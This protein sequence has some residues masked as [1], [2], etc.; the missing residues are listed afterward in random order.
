MAEPW[1]LINIDGQNR[2]LRLDGVALRDFQLA[3][4]KSIGAENYPF[5]KVL[6]R[7]YEQATRFEVVTDYNLLAHL[8]W[9][10]LKWRWQ[11][12]TVDQVIQL[13][14]RLEEQ[15]HDLLAEVWAPLEQAW[16]ATGMFKTLIKRVEADQAGGQSGNGAGATETTPAVEPSP[17]PSSASA[18]GSTTPP[19]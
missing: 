13:L 1:M 6:A 11:T 2:P 16:L 3:Y 15:G 17:S 8:V 19:A 9:A 18:A 10:G 4:A 5:G 7:Y 14:S 12:L